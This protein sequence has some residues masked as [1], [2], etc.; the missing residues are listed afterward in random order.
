[1]G[2]ST[3]DIMHFWQSI[4]KKVVLYLRFFQSNFTRDEFLGQDFAQNL[5]SSDLMGKGTV[6]FGQK[7][8]PNVRMVL[9]CS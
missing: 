5:I 3:H 8:L 7:L 2:S 9:N 4:F 6:F 1:M